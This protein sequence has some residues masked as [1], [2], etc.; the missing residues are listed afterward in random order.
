MWNPPTF[1]VLTTCDFFGCN[2]CIT[3]V[4]VEPMVLNDDMVEDIQPVQII[5]TVA[6]LPPGG[7]DGDKVSDGG[8]TAPVDNLQ[9]LD[10][11]DSDD[12]NVEES[13]VRTMSGQAVCAPRQ[14]YCEMGSMAA[15]NYEIA[16]LQPEYIFYS[17]MTQLNEDVGELA[18]MATVNGMEYAMMDAKWAFTGTALGGGC[19]NTTELHMMNYKEAMELDDKEKWLAAMK[20]E[21]ER[22]V[23]NMVWKAIPPS[24]SCGHGPSRRSR[25]APIVPG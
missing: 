19:K 22:M 23:K 18:C 16:L 24:F 5:T 10:D 17:V 3:P 20:E 8:E 7:K 14:L 15:S 6:G 2:A 21:H 25:M 12:N 13:E 11:M 4:V 9:P 1:G